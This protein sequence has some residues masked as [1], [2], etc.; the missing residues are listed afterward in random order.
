MKDE[1]I[2]SDCRSCKRETKHT[3]LGKTSNVTPPELYHDETKYFLLECNGCTTVSFRKEYHDYESYRQT[4]PDDYEHDISVEVFPHSIKNHSPIDSLFEIPG[5]V[6]SIYKESLLAIQEGALTLAGLGLRATIEAICN[7]K[8]VKGKNLQVRIN[9]MNR[10]GMISKSDAERLHAIR[11]MGN[12]AAH[13]IKKAKENSILIALKII[14]HVLLSVYVFE[15]EVNQHLEKPISSLEEA[16][17]ILESNLSRIETNSTFTLPKW[18][19]NSRR[20]VLDN[21]D[22]IESDLIIKIQNGDLK[23]VEIID[24]QE[25]EESTPQLYKKIVTEVADEVDLD[26]EN[27]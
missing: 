1:I 20:R 9:A 24:T 7:D 25:S 3:V 23:E 13:E 4:G 12:D 17:P 19:G 26:E 10:S 8:K 6:E 22:V 18:L 27:I 11:F 2:W 14:E 21:L 15:E 16:L 5:I